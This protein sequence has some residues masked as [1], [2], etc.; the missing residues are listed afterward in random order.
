MRQIRRIFKDSGRGMAVAPSVRG[1]FR[2]VPGGFSALGPDLPPD[3]FF[4]L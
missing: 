1:D 3:G 4:R 2:R